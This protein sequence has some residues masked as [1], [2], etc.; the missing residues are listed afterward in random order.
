MKI[1]EL[2][3]GDRVKWVS[4][5]PLDGKSEMEGTVKSVFTDHI[6]VDVP[7]VND[8]CWFDDDLI[9]E[10]NYLVKVR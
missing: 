8:H 9:D 1:S 6:L 7:Q 3:V 10:T 5:D 2:K 4:I